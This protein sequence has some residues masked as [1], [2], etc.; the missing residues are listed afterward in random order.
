MASA[1][2]RGTSS[3][4]FTRKLAAYLAFPICVERTMKRLCA[5]G[6]RCSRCLSGHDCSVFAGGGVTTN[7][8]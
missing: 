6:H 4:V 3:S 5:S 8:E 7:N 1:V 2:K